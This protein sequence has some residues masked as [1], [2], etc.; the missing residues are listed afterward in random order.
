M[1]SGRQNLHE[2]L[3]ARRPAN[4]SGTGSPTGDPE[5]TSN[6]SYCLAGFLDNREAW[7]FVDFLLRSEMTDRSFLL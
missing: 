2:N 6:W 5:I 1:A 7:F 4:L 3:S